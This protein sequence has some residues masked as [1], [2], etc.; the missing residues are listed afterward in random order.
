[1][2]TSKQTSMIFNYG[3]TTYMSIDSF[4]NEFKMIIDNDIIPIITF[5]N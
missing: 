5:C 3:N 4:N 2:S 1:M